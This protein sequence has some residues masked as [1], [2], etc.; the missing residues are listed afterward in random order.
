M[1]ALEHL[2]GDDL[3]ALSSP[4]TLRRA[5]RD[6]DDTAM[7]PSSSSTD[8]VGVVTVCWADAT[9]TFPGDRLS[10]ARCSCPARRLCRHRVRSILFLQKRSTT[11]AADTEGWTPAVWPLLSLEQAAGRSVWRRALSARSE[12]VEVSRESETSAT[13]P[14]LGIRVRF[15]P[16]LPLSASVCSCGAVGVCAHRVLAALLWQPH[17]PGAAAADAAQSAARERVWGR[18][19]SLLS[20]GL[21]GTPSESA[22]GLLALSQQTSQHLP[23]PARDLVALADTISGYQARS[24]RGSAQQWLSGVGRLGARLLALSSPDRKAP[25]RLLRGRSRRAHLAAGRLDVL[26]LGAE[27][28]QSSRGV[29]IKCWF[30]VAETGAWVH[31][32]VGRGVAPGEEPLPPAALW[33]APLWG[34]QAA[35]DVVDGRVQLSGAALSPDGGLSTSG[36]TARPQPGPLQPGDLPAGVVAESVGALADRWVQQAPPILRDPQARWLPAVIALAEG[37][38]ILDAPTFSEAGQQL[39]VPVAL[40]SGESIRLQVVASTGTERV[41]E[42][43]ERL[44]SW[45]APPSHLLVR[46]WPTDGGIAAVPISAWMAGQPRPRSLGLGAPLAPR[47]RRPWRQVVTTASSPVLDAPL[48][49]LRG[50]LDLLESLAVEGLARSRWRLPQ[51]QSVAVGLAGLGLTEGAGQVSALAA[52]LGALSLRADGEA[53]GVARRFVALLAWATAVEEAWLLRRCRR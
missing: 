24:A 49:A 37:R 6:L 28:F 23:G 15:L 4:L 51:L 26:G 47:S 1:S 38:P 8:G 36:V 22:E 17:V 48:Q 9:C 11:T 14:A 10:E 44:R 16:G 40:R 33:R 29:V 5:Q 32:T 46:F 21:D 31:A 25:P 35:C 50:L 3:Q 30:V 12:G 39:T 2:S 45:P 13:L 18:V 7:V 53:D 41:V 42:A 20:A 34:D 43:L 19:V 27:G 52:A